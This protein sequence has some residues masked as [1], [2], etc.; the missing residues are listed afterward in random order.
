M[1]RTSAACAAREQNRRLRCDRGGEI[2]L[3]NGKYYCFRHAPQGAELDPDPEIRFA[4]ASMAY[5]AV[6]TAWK[7]KSEKQEVDGPGAS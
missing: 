3:K 4:F 5:P 7:K 1:I 6:E 2:W